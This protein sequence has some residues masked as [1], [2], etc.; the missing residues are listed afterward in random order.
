MA[1]VTLR[2]R[3]YIKN[4]LL[5]RKQFVVDLL[6][7][8][9]AAPTRQEIIEQIAKNMKATKELVSVFGIE[10]KMG[11]GR[12]TGF[13]FIYDNKDALLKT[14]PRYR[15]IRAGLAE[16]KTV[17]RRARKNTRK[18]QAKVWGSGKRAAQH[19]E[20]RQKRKEEM[21]GN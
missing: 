6:H 17:T 18:E 14:E 10:T 20:R 8:G 5:Q 13:G 9:Q 15:L 11:G 1:P 3:K 2:I 7:E 16:K 4:T 19:K 12:T 21:G